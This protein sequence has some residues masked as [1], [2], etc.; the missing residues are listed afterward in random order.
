MSRL[1]STLS[2]VAGLAIGGALQAQEASD[3]TPTVDPSV[4]LDLGQTVQ[5]DPSYVKEVYDDWQL[6]C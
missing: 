1:L 2:L 6:Q 3:G 5:E 4:G